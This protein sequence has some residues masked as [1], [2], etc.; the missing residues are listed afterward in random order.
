M[1]PAR[2]AAATFW[3]AVAMLIATAAF[4]AIVGGAAG[5]AGFLAGIGCAAAAFLAYQLLRSR[6]RDDITLSPD[7]RRLRERRGF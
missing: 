2:Q 3:V 1:K 6:R 4:F 5:S 7:A